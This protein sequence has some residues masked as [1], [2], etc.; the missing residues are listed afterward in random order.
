MP[1]F[2]TCTCVCGLTPREFD[3]VLRRETNFTTK[4]RELCHANIG[5][6]SDRSICDEHLIKDWA[7]SGRVGVYLLWHK[8]DFCAAH[9]LFHMRALYVGKGHVERR[10]L[11][12]WEEKDFTEELIVYWTFVEMPNR[13]AKYCEQLLLDLYFF[14]FNKSENPGSVDLCAH[15]TQVEVD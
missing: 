7:L 8:D 9:E 6:Y 4:I 15:L 13:Q 14:P 5:W 11:K 12:H 2:S 10:L 3:E 1:C